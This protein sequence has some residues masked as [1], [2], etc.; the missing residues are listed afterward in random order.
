MRSLAIILGPIVAIA[1]LGI[2][3]GG[4]PLRPAAAALLT[5]LVVYIGGGFLPGAQQ[6]TMRGELFELEPTPAWSVM[7]SAVGALCLIGVYIACALWA[8]GVLP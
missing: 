2:V 4:D 6:V 1:L 5:S 3:F 7:A 8:V